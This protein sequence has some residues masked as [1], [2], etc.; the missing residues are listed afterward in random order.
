MFCCAIK[1][2]GRRLAAASDDEDEQEEGDMLDDPTIDID[3]LPRDRTLNSLDNLRALCQQQ[4]Y[5]F[6][7]I[8]MAKYA[9]PL[10]R[11]QQHSS[12]ATGNCGSSI[13]EPQ[14]NLIIFAIR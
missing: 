8:R 12:Q 13:L 6:D 5:Q 14:L 11:T 4:H 3:E 10:A 2:I 7:T 9:C 1:L